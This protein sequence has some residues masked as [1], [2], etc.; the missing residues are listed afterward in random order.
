MRR[1]RL[2]A[3]VLATALLLVGCTEQGQS[4][5]DADFGGAVQQWISPTTE[6]VTF[7]GGTVD[8]GRFDSKQYLGRV[9]VV[10]FWYAQCPPCRAEA[11]GL[12][13]LSTQFAGDDVQFVGVNTQDAEG[14]AANFDREFGIDYPSILDAGDAT[15]QLAF[16]GSRGPK[17]T[18]STLVLDRKGRVTARIVGLAD[19][20]ILKTFVQDAVDGKAA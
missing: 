17:A 4:S 12:K 11:P 6:P 13:K 19:P 3:P 18:P 16:S 20:S 8:G 5:T 7:S 14:E 15:V 1:L 10:N 2:I 9:V